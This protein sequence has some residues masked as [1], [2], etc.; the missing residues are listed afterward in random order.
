MGTAKRM[1]EALR[2]DD[3]TRIGVF[4]AVLAGTNAAGRP[5]WLQ[6]ALMCDRRAY[7]HCGSGTDPNRW[8]AAK[9]F[10]VV[11]VAIVAGHVTATHLL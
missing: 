9:V 5:G 4:A 8:F 1:A 7:P 6:E 10:V 2:L 11:V 3:N